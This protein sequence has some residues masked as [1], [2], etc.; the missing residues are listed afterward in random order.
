MSKK[1]HKRFGVIAVEK[2]FISDD[3]LLQAL[4][5]QAE[6][7][8]KSGKHRLLGQILLDLGFMTEPQIEE[9]LEV[10]NQQLLLMLA[11]GR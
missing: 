11:A 5:L 6:E 1:N 10:I 3:Q 4:S 9:V 8:L 7:N 2:G